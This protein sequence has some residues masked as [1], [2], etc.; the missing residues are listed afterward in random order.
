VITHHIAEENKTSFDRNQ[1]SSINLGK[2]KG[3]TVLSTTH[4]NKKYRE[5]QRAVLD[6]YV[7]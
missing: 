7:A 1:I 4:H 5:F 2:R 6:K 3:G